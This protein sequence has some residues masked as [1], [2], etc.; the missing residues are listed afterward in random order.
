MKIKTMNI[1]K[2]LCGA[3]PAIEK[4]PITGNH[5]IEELFK[6]RCPNCKEKELPWL[7]QW[8]HCGAWEEWNRIAP[9][10]SYH[11]RTLEYNINGACVAK[12]YKVFEWHDKKKYNYL[13]IKIYLDNGM[14]YYCRDYWWK[15]GGG[16]NGVWIGEPG[17]P[18]LELA[19]L[20][21]I[22]KKLMFAEIQP[23]L[24]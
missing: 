24:F 17:L 1:E 3:E 19:N 20:E 23:E 10:R 5:A 22:A 16:A 15:D 21:K 7:G 8:P 14:Y 2:C 9:K 11:K 4:K 13:T 6:Y 18:S 12:P